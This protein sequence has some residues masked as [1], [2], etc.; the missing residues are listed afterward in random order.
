MVDRIPLY[1]GRVELVPVDGEINKY[2]LVRADEAIEQ[3]TSLNKANLLND[4][5]ARMLELTDDTATVNN[6]L[7][8]L[9]EKFDKGKPLST[10]KMVQTGDFL[11]GIGTEMGLKKIEQTET[12]QPSKHGL[13]AGDT[14]NVLCVGG[15]QGGGGGG[16]GRSTT[17]A[18]SNY[19]QNGG[20]AGEPSSGGSGAG[21]GAGGGGGAGGANSYNTSSGGASGAGG[22]SGCLEMEVIVLTENDI[23]NGILAT[24]GKGGAGG[25]FNSNSNDT[26]ATKGEAGGDTT[27]GEYVIA[28][29]GSDENYGSLGGAS[30]ASSSTNP[31]GGGAGG[32]IVGVGFGGNGGNS[33]IS[34]PEIAPPSG[35]GGG[36]GG[37]ATSSSRVFSFTEYGGRI[38][39]KG[40][41]AV[42]DGVVIVFW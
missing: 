33:Y 38:G 2:D 23:K 12:F 22:N 10:F 21:Y 17:T 8:A 11:K 20:D 41:H 15:G 9:F 4:E 7:L 14:I 42:G 27:F 19:G 30:R 40:Q 26:S 36:Y 34:D 24:I 5:V 13:Q 32:L 31:G 1:P 16:R 37:V 25:G 3:G 28:K 6:A 18:Y 29:G 35:L 39:T